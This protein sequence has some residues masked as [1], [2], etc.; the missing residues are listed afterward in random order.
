MQNTITPARFIY[1]HLYLLIIAAWL[2]TISFVI[3]NYWSANSS[4]YT[5]QKKLDNYIKI[6]ENDFEN[7]INDKAA[8][9]KIK[10]HSID[11][12]LLNKL[13]K[14]DYF[15][16]YYQTTNT[17]SDSLVC[18]NTQKVVPLPLMLYGNEKNGFLK[19]DNGYY[20]WER[21]DKDN[22][23][24]IALIPVKWSYFIENE[25]LQNDFVID[26]SIT[27]NY[28]I[29]SQSKNAAVIK[30]VEGKPLF[31][32]LEKRSNVIHKNNTIA[33]WL[34]LT[35]L[36]L[37]LFFIHLVASFCC[38]E[39]NM[40]L[41]I[42]IL[43]LLII[44]LR[45]LSYFYFFPVNFRQFEIFDPTIYGNGLVLRSLGDLFINSFI[46]IWFVLFL[47]SQIVANNFKLK[48]K[49]RAQ[50]IGALA[51]SSSLILMVSF[52]SA[53][54]IRSLVVDSQIS[55]DV[56]NF[57]TLN[58]Y[59]VIGFVVLCLISI[60][61][62][63][64]CQVILYLIKP[65]FNKIVIPLLLSVITISL[66]FLSFRIG[67]I[68]GGFEIYVLL[69]LIVFLLLLNS[70]FSNVLTSK[71]ISSKLA[72]WLVFFSVSI[73]LIILEEN[74]KKEL[75]SRKHYAE[76]LALKSDPAN[77]TL[78]KSMLLDFS[79]D[80][81]KDNFFRFKSFN[82]NA[83]LKDSLISSNSS[84]YSNKYDTHLYA[85]SADEK[86]LFNKD[87]TTYNDINTILNNQ[88][89]PTGVNGLYY[90]DQS[91]DLFSYLSKKTI[92]DSSDNLIGY[93]FI[94]ATPKKQRGDALYPE[95]FSKG[96]ANS[97]E[98]SSSYAFAIYNDWKLISS[99]NDY[100]FPSVLNQKELKQKDFV[101]NKKDNYSELIF[102]AG[103]GKL[104]I[105]SKENDV[106][107]E[108]ITLF[109]YLFCSFLLVSALLWIIHILV[110]ARLNRKKIFSYWQFSIR[111]QI[112]GT[113]IFISVIS[114]LVIGVATILFFIVHYESNNR[115]KLIRVIRIMEKEVK[116]TISSGWNVKDTCTFNNIDYDKRLEEVV[117]KISDIHGVDVNLYDLNGN[118]R[119]SSLPLPYTKGILS[120]RIDPIA[121][122]HLNNKKEIQ[123]F[124]K[125]NIG[126]LTFI[127]NYIPVI[128]AEGNNYAFLNIPYF[129]SQN[130]LK[131]EIS[132]FL[133]TIINLNAFIFLLA[134][135]VSLFITNKISN[136]FSLI[137]E[138]MKRINLGTHNETIDWKKDDEIG[139]LVLEYNK[140]VNKLEESAIILA[141]TEREGA[142][143][144]MARQVAHEI[145]NPLTPM[146]LS[147]QY[148]QKSIQNKSPNI[149]ELAQNVSNTLIEQIDHLSNIAN[150]FSQFANI[151]EAKK[152]VFDLNDTLRNVILLHEINDNLKINRALLEEKQLIRADKTQI[153]RLFTNL[154][155]NAIQ[156]VPS[157]REAVITVSELITDRHIIIKIKDNGQGISE[158][159][160]LK[161]FTPNFTTKSSGTGLGLAM[162][163]RIV[164]QSEGKI[165]F[166]T[167]VGT[168]TTFFVKLPL[169][170]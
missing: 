16:F 47:R 143:K 43:F 6:Q 129:T 57:F 89:K 49:N 61:H 82:S 124:Q 158:E 106:S 41:G 12:S 25:Y 100:P 93:L 157:E 166:E 164:E 125:E 4:L 154:I 38:K 73:S 87:S 22:I 90:F 156:S 98:N 36:L 95:L 112:H 40:W 170:S 9:N 135:I 136:S 97:I 149:N 51:F 65:S 96:K 118:L 104:V 115:E 67:N 28:D 128:D 45:V 50:K 60:S 11:E 138:K 19:M 59:S 88:S 144:E 54:I 70:R 84:G 18:W 79:D 3:D 26:K 29:S 17:A 133:I 5:V 91:F 1:K 62:Y 147:M 85:F 137:T 55:F 134:G 122:Y 64:F 24:V 101:V 131:Q 107:I 14:K 33:I 163:K 52:I 167:E 99:H 34:Q 30:N 148:L 123:Y 71:V 31:Y 116:S 142:W 20:V 32:V 92:R 80:F 15:V 23:K 102:N 69:W 94:L 132:N 103:D 74:S 165:W 72:F 42:F 151:G 10:L 113:I 114:F 46:F 75:E 126:N 130:I 146:K 139:A 8:F 141:K 21:K 152:E 83:A 37:V 63:F 161:I 77:E 150:A 140:M 35:A 159:I 58:Q 109:S 108:S 39:R 120:T 117:Q 153:N 110:S 2:I 53:N 111:N 44:G 48:I 7:L 56:T 169:E 119:I 127:S 162:C 160:S 13:I 68:K 76:I 145:K 81:L 155:L 168:G 27:L 105:I 66:L 121:F 86:Q 78:I